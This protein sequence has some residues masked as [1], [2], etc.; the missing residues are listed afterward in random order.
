MV[1]IGFICVK[2]NSKWNFWRTAEFICLLNIMQGIWRQFCFISC[3]VVIF[4]IINRTFSV[5]FETIIIVHRPWCLCHA[6]VNLGCLCHV[7]CIPQHWSTVAA[8]GV[9]TLSI[10]WVVLM[11]HCHFLYTKVLTLS[12]HSFLYYLKPFGRR[13]LLML[14]SLHS[15]NLAFCL[16]GFVL[17]VWHHELLWPGWKY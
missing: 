8:L 17:N 7:L 4:F 14:R 13:F 5:C 16:F 12:H 3:R 10:I 2:P 6:L 15:N 9:L 1:E 11:R